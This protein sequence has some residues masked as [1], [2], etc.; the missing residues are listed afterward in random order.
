MT[1]IRSSTV[2]ITGGASGIGRLMAL[3]FA[4]R[5]ATVAILDVN[6]EG[7]RIVAKE[8]QA[9]TGRE[10]AAFEVDITDRYAVAAVAD[11][12]REAVGDPD[13]VVNNAGIISGGAPLLETPDELIE[14]TMGVNVLAL[15]WVTKAFLPAM[16]ARDR[17]HVVTIA[18][19]SGMVGVS[20]L[21]EY[22]AS[23]H[24]AIGFDESL[25]MELAELAPGV[26]TTIVN[27]FYIDTGMFDGVATKVPW[28]LPILDA[29]H[30]ADRVIDAVAT[31][32]RRVTLPRAVNLL[33]PAHFLPVRV[34]D[35]IV[36]ALGV[37]DT[38]REF[39]GRVPPESQVPS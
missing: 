1:D 33:Y 12:V 11:Q 34:F 22:S 19:A 25:R 36:N 10:H 17:G 13:V 9:A 4:A 32:R 39:K 21:V 38:M 18:S 29:Q 3:G 8:M 7:A 5:G 27:P 24:A 26:R 20:R 15:F 14:L 16:V 35:R 28:L 30:V 23:K 6:L 31:D 37:N 2:V